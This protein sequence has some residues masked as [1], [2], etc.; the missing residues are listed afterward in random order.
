MLPDYPEIKGRLLRRL[1]EQIQEKARLQAPLFSRIA[2]YC[3]HEGDSFEIEGQDGSKVSR[4]FIEYKRKFEV[5]VDG[6]PGELARNVE[7]EIDRTADDFAE[8][9]ERTILNTLQDATKG[10]GIDAGGQPPSPELLIEALDKMEIDF[11]FH[12]VLHMPKFLV[13]PDLAPA[14]QAAWDTLRTN[15][16]YRDKIE[17][18]IT[19]KRRE[20]VIRQSHRKLVG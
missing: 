15:A 14:L 2:S 10:R 3:Q 19:R 12:G 5:L 20:W 9:A 6:T 16:K 17:E 13:H 18:L 11:D 1:G 8:S 7:T 4:R